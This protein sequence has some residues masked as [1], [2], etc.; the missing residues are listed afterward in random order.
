MQVPAI[1]I[2][3][4]MRERLCQ[5]AWS[6]DNA[7]L[8][9]ELSL[10]GIDCYLENLK[11]RL[12]QKSHGIRWASMRAT[13]EGLLVFARYSG[14]TDNILQHLRSYFREFEARENAQ[15][16]LKFFALLRTGNTT[17]KLIDLADNLLAGVAAEERPKKRHQMRNGAA[18]LAIFANAP[19]RNAS[20]QLVFGK[21]LFWEQN[22][23][24]I[25]TEIQKTHTRR[26]EEF[27]FPLHQEIGRFI[28][29]LILGDASPAMLPK[30]RENLQRIRRQLFV[31]PD[32]APAAATYIPRVFRV[33][34][35]NSF[36]T[37]RVMLY[38][39]AV[40]HHGLEGIELAKP[41]AHHSSTEI[42]KKHYIA[43][44]VAEVYVTNFQ[45]RRQ[46]RMGN[47]RQDYDTLMS[48]LE[49]AVESKT[50]P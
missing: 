18:I 41:A 14:E 24:V 46:Q 39:D 23:W 27:V 9:R 22:E 34:T 15:R 17:D 44:Q 26:P 40:T 13:T 36:T 35:G 29:E 37:L 7:G 12:S 48:A 16:A 6:A 25:R 20:A 5:Y 32:G 45:R 3:L 33:L 49:S 8:S 43:E 42:V 21:S 19:L 38:S 31:L 11:Q 30:L 2:V 4:R 50:D 10:D 28:D 47:S 1:S